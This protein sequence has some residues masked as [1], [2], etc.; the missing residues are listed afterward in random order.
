MHDYRINAQARALFVR[1]NVDLNKVEHGT[2]NGVIYVRGAL[3]NFSF[4]RSDELGESRLAE[5][6]FVHRVEKTLR[7]IPGVRDVVFQLERVV[8]VGTR[9]KPK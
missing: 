2:T 7:R 4:D 1:L 9:W 3:R 6:A 8:K 5:A